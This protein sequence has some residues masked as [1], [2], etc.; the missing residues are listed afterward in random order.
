M[1]IPFQN[2]VKCG[3]EKSSKCGQITAKEVL[4]AC[5]PNCWCNPNSVETHSWKTN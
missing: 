5:K 4:K 1:R 3:S 2:P